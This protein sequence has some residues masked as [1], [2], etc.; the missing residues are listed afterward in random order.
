M[1]LL[2]ECVCMYVCIESKIT[3][4]EDLGYTTG[5]DWT[6]T[7]LQCIALLLNVFLKQFGEVE[8]AVSRERKEKVLKCC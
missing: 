3:G 7:W 2:C 4:N 6:R 1:H 5:F 8:G